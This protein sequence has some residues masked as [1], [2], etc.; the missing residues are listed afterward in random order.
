MQ[1]IKNAIKLYVSNL[2]KLKNEY[3]IFYQYLL[4]LLFHLFSHIHTL[5]HLSLFMDAF[6]VLVSVVV[7]FYYYS[8]FHSNGNLPISLGF[9]PLIKKTILKFIYPIENYATFFM[10]LLSKLWS[11]NPAAHNVQKIVFTNLFGCTH[12]S[13]KVNYHQP[14]MMYITL[15]LS[16][17]K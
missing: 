5:A 16:Q 8:W 4:L 9:T 11:Q 2:K 13:P 7:F 1:C 3:R 15:H 14:T 6:I 10:C 17:Y 12:F